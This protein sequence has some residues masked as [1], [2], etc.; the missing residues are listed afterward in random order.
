MLQELRKIWDQSNKTTNIT[1][2]EQ[3]V[4]EC[5][6]HLPIKYVSENTTEPITGLECDMLVT[7]YKGQDVKLAVE[8]NGVF[9]FPRNSED[10][11]GR[12]VIKKRV[13]E[14]RA[15]FKVLTVPYFHWYILE[16]RQKV[17]Y[18]RDSVELTLS[19]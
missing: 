11:L 16:D 18:L 3:D 15:G 8:A 7:Q 2:F 1:K 4:T 12:D 5:M 14:R 10:P 6:R 17:G 19:K 13:L 9:H